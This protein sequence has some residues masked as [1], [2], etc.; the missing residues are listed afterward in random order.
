MSVSGKMLPVGE[1]TVDSTELK[2]LKQAHKE[3][4]DFKL[5]IKRGELKPNLRATMYTY[6]I[7]DKIYLDLS[8]FSQALDVE[9]FEV[10]ALL[11]ALVALHR[12]GYMP[13]ASSDVEIPEDI[14]AVPLFMGNEVV[15]EDDLE[16]IGKLKIKSSKH[17]CPTADLPEYIVAE[18]SN[19]ESE[20]VEKQQAELQA[21]KDAYAELE[22]SFA[23]LVEEKAELEIK[24]KSSSPKTESTEAK[25]ETKTAPNKRGRPAKT[26]K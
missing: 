22:K 9:P 11:P 2:Q 13:V 14:Y 15:A 12:E 4:V 21:V 23:A 7:D 1:H 19:L 10:G 17:G 26:K 5:F 3:G 18:T 6:Q 20:L 16:V 25:K 8:E 24:L